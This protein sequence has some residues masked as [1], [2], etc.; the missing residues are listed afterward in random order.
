MKV[1]ATVTG[2]HLIDKLYESRIL[3]IESAIPI[4]KRRQPSIISIIDKE[5]HAANEAR[6][7]TVEVRSNLKKIGISLEA[8]DDDKSSDRQEVDQSASVRH[9]S[10]H[11]SSTHFCA[12]LGSRPFLTEGYEGLPINST[13]PAGTTLNGI[14]YVNF[15]VGTEGRIDNLFGRIGDASL[16]LQRGGNNT[17]FLSQ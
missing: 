7:K 3:L 5:K 6:S 9:M 1:D 16:A 10:T 17:S 11:M 4:K 15:P 13:I 2:V 12:A 8:I 14:T